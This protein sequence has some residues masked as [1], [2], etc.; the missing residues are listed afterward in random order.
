[1]S[2]S[3]STVYSSS[4]FRSGGSPASVRFGPMA[5][6]ASVYAGA[7]G[8]GSRISVSRS[9]SLGSSL[10]G[11]YGA[12]GYG[13]GG[14][15]FSLSLSGSGVVQNEKETMQ[16][17]NDRLASYLEKVRSLEADNRRLE[18]Q[19]REFMDKKGP[20]TRDWS[21]YFEIIEDLRNQ[22][23]RDTPNTPLGACLRS[24]E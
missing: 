22:V 1:M 10:A 4:S 19:I 13:A 14:S 24:W 7:G 15:G 9:S 6:A 2:Y 18:L 3:K 5:S 21:H 12:G 16:D 17:L 8:S 20:S 23:R 11:G